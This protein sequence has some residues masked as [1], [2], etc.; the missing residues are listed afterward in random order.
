MG[1]TMVIWHPNV[2]V[3]DL[4]Y[5][6]RQ[7]NQLQVPQL[8]KLAHTST[9]CDVR[10]APA[11]PLIRVCVGVLASMTP[12]THTETGSNI[13]GATYSVFSYINSQNQSKS[14]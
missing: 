7:V 9:S 11:S 5:R 12:S 4:G 2:A 3:G 10:C 13:K 8:R 14:S 1:V 6:Q